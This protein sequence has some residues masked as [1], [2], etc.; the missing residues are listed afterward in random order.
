MADVHEI[1]V[2]HEGPVTIIKIN[3]PRV[4]N[5]I[6]RATAQALKDA[7]LAFE[8]DEKAL[9]AILTGG[10]EVFCAGADLNGVDELAADVEGGGRATGIHALVCQQTDDR[11]GGRLLCGRWIRD[12]LLV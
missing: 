9:V 8:A 3:R 5:A 12:S 10:D 6:N 7:W 1:E 2:S 11:C 4:R